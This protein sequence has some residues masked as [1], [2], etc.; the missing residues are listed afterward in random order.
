MDPI[1]ISLL[2]G[3]QALN[4]FSDTGTCAMRAASIAGVKASCSLDQASTVLREVQRLKVEE[5]RSEIEFGGRARGCAQP[6]QD[7]IYL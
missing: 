6:K 3:R 5:M 4:S 7:K 1:R 2:S